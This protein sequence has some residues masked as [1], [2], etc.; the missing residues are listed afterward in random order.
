[1]G[2]GLAVAHNGNIYFSDPL[3]QK[4]WF[5]NAR[6]AKKMVDEGIAFPNGLQLTPDQSLLQVSDTKGQFVYSFQVEADGSLADKQRYFYLH[7]VDGSMQSGAEGMAVDTEGRLYVTTE[8]GIQVCD[9]AGRV[10]AIISKPQRDRVAA[11]AFGG[12]N[13][14]ELYVACDGKLYKR[15]INAKGVFSFEAPIKPPAPHL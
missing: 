10:Q 3:N 8:M 13:R 9:Q 6:N 2:S 1:M 5:L 14:D 7:L 11:I 12:A 4:I 15:K